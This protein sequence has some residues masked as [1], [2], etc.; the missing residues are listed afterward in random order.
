MRPLLFVTMLAVMWMKPS[1]AAEFYVGAATVESTPPKPVSLAGQFE[2][3][4]SK[5]NATPLE[6]TALAMQSRE[7]DKVIDQAVSV[8]CD[9]VAIRAGVIEELRKRLDGKI[10]GLDLN[11][12]FLN[13]TH[14]HT[15]PVTTLEDVDYPVP[16]GAMT[17]KEY[18][19]FFIDRVAEAIEKSW[20]NLQPV[21]LGYAQSEA[22]VGHNRRATYAN[23]TAV[24]YGKTNNP[25]FR[26]TEGHEE[27][28][29]DVLYFWDKSD[30]LIATV[31]NI[32]CPSQEEEHLRVVHA[33]FW[34]SVRKKLRSKYGANLHIL[35][36]A[37]ASGDVVPHLMYDK[38]ADER[39]RKL[40]GLNRLDDI[41][42]RIVRG[43]EDAYEIAQLDKI[44]NPVLK[45]TV[46]HIELPL[47]KV[48]SEE[49]ALAKSEMEKFKG[50]IT[51]ANRYN[52]NKRVV[53]RA[54]SIQDG[55]AKP[56]VMELHALRLGDV[57]IGTNPFELFTAYGSQMKARSPGT[58]TFVIQLAGPGTYL[59]TELAVKGGGY[60]AVIQSNTVGPE[61]GQVLV[62]ETVS[63]W[64]QLWDGEL[65]KK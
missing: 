15:G 19:S 59:P 23:G 53:D 62:E 37:G 38:K 32:A 22:V 39:M 42:R 54:L 14:T 8:S 4:I 56:Y 25:D 6:V 13:A 40:R 17:P 28:N 36:W 30:K 64:S 55:T 1:H 58:Q 3:R 47:R 44:E 52:W 7:G 16:E 26:G 20:K 60:S 46:K 29:L 63:A 12:I 61:G 65:E 50:D 9:L 45:H 11:K 57:A 24:M 41:A 35:P 51:K 31:I 21:K 10:E 43:W 2:I 49:L 34:D 48:S 33:D 27:H 18:T 5:E